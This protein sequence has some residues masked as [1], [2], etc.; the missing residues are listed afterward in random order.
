MRG[1]KLVPERFQLTRDA[2][3]SGRSHVWE[4]RRQT[5]TRPAPANR[6]AA[7]K[8]I[9]GLTSA[10]STALVAPVTNSAPPNNASRQ[11][12]Q[13]AAATTG[14]NQVTRDIANLLSSILILEAGSRSTDAQGQTMTGGRLLVGWG[15]VDEAEVREPFDEGLLQDAAGAALDDEAIGVDE[16]CGGHAETAIELEDGAIS[17]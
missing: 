17:V 3:L 9:Q 13:A 15:L 5:M 1:Y 14:A 8:S 4:R 7:A 10:A 11:G 2:L 12:T 6:G 16:Q